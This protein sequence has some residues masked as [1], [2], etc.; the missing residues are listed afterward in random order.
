MGSSIKNNKFEL[1]IFKQDVITKCIDTYTMYPYILHPRVPRLSP[2]K[3]R[4]GKKDEELTHC[5]AKNLY[6]CAHMM[7]FGEIWKLH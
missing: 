3:N 7:P 2:G 6:V 5:C 4:F 1:Y